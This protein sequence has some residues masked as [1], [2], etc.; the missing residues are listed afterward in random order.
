MSQIRNKPKYRRI[1]KLEGIQGILQ[2]A[3][4]RRG[5][6][7]AIAKYQFVLKWPEIVGGEIAKRTRPEFLK[8]GTL[9]VR[10]AESVWA[11]ELT[12]QKDVI[13]NRLK[14]YVPEKDAVTDVKFVVGVLSPR[15]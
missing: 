6:D 5:L 1:S 7:Q 14:R 4:K 3:L 12:F 2:G 15:P 11:Q 10:V 8:N 9:F 13:L